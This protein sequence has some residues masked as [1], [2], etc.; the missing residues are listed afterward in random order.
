[1]TAPPSYEYASGDGA[2]VTDVICPLR[3]ITVAAAGS[4]CV[5]AAT[6]IA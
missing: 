5:V 1:M 3:S 2:C 6:V 4:A